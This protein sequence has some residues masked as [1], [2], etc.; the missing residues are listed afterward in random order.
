MRYWDLQRF[1]PGT[2]T[3]THNSIYNNGTRTQKIQGYAV[4][5]GVKADGTTFTPSSTND[6]KPLAGSNTVDGWTYATN[7]LG[8]QDDTPLIKSYP[9]IRDQTI[10]QG[11]GNA[12]A[13]YASLGYEEDIQ[14]SQFE[15]I[16]PRAE[17]YELLA[18]GDLFPAS[19]LR[20]NN[21]GYYT[22]DYSD[23][24]IVLEG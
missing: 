7:F 18:V 22:K 21:I 1:N 14:Y 6:S 24:A 11:Y 17:T 9:T 12:R 15:Q 10:G 4:A 23:Y 20:H 8:N 16:D 2:L 13:G 3:K 19:K 5:Y